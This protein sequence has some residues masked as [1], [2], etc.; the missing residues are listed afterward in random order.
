MDSQTERQSSPSTNNCRKQGSFSSCH[1]LRQILQPITERAI[2]CLSTSPGNRGLKNSGVIETNDDRFGSRSSSQKT[3]LADVRFIAF[4]VKKIFEFFSQSDPDE[5]TSRRT[6]RLCCCSRETSL[7]SDSLI[8][9]G[10][11]TTLD[12]SQRAARGR[13][14]H[15]SSCTNV[16]EADEAG[17]SPNSAGL[18]AAFPASTAGADCCA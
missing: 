3:A 8:N 11:A 12:S 2:A 6:H 17:A 4:E 10:N 13:E 16:G 18:I 1:I 15:R 5:V 9:V 7:M 14:V